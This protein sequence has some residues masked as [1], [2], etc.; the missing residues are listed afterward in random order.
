MHAGHNKYLN[1]NYSIC[2]LAPQTAS[3]VFKYLASSSE[4]SKGY[5]NAGAL[6]F[7]GYCWDTSSSTQVPYNKAST[8]A[9]ADRITQ[10]YENDQNRDN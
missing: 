4:R 6:Y 7:L 10:Q 1:T 8:G 2:I 5:E 3:L 9:T